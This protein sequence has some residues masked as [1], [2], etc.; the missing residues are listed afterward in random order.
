MRSRKFF[1]CLFVFLFVLSFA[2]CA[3]EVKTDT[4]SAEQTQQDSEFLTKLKALPGVTDV[5]PLRSRRETS[6]ESYS[7]MF[8]QPVDHKKPNGAKFTQ[9]VFVS[10]VGYDKPVLLGTEGYSAR[11][12]GGGEL[13]GMLQ[14]NRVTVEHRFFGGSK[15]TPLDWKYMTVKNSADDLHAVVTTLKKLYTGKWVSTGASKGGQTSLFYKCYYPEDMDAVVAYV[16]PINLAQEDPRLYQFLETVGD[17]ETREKIK[18]FQIAMLKRQDELLPAIKEQSSQMA[19]KIGLP[20]AFEYSILEY[21]FAFWQYGTS[22]DSIPEPNASAE[23]MLKH[24]NSVRTLYYYSDGGMA[25][26]EAFQYQA[27]SEIGYYNYDITDFKPYLKTLK[28]PTNKVLCPDGVEITYDARTM[29]FVYNFL[30]YKA[31]R[32]V[33]IYGGDDTWS[34]TQLPLIGRTDALKFVNEGKNHGT[35]VRDFSPEEKK[36]FYAAMERWLGFE[37]NKP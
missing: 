24:Y 20:A 29:A 17:A 16:A 13:H 15:P 31:D 5:K 8:E 27:F 34:A 18:Q 11:G 28:N 26:F 37:L 1:V 30:Q 33:Y 3:A 22:P 7:F 25:Q 19:F 4:A 32:V 35:G 6:G 10:H 14:G 36:Q 21:P 9:R 12:V 23:E 2:A